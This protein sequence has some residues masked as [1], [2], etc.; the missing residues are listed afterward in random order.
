MINIRKDIRSTI[1]KINDIGKENIVEL[2]TDLNKFMVKTKPNNVSIL[3]RAIPDLDDVFPNMLLVIIVAIVI[4][5][6]GGISLAFMF[7]Y[8]DDLVRNSTHLA[9]ATQWLFLGNVQE[10]KSKLQSKG[11]IIAHLYPLDPVSEAYRIIR[12][13]LLF[14]S[15]E[16]L[17]IK[18][19]SIISNGLG[20]GKTT[21]ACNLAIVMS[22]IGKKVLLID[23]N[24]HKPKLD[25]IFNLK[26][27]TGLG[28]F[29][30][31]Q[32]TIEGIV[33]V[34][35]TPNL[36][37][38]TSGPNPTNPTELISGDKLKKLINMAKQNYDF[39]ILDTAPAG[40]FADA[41][42]IASIVDATIVVVDCKRTPQR[43]LSKIAAKLNE[44][45][46]PKTFFILNR[47]LKQSE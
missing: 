27:S 24:L 37:V 13:S 47:A 16:N 40:L 32:L 28:G 33:N 35:K 4:G 14:Q 44:A 21:T 30:G 3:Q 31:G 6:W 34:I 15:T 2:E 10:M 25:R 12:T 11:N 43:A 7:N 5:L 42:I 19:V 17:P 46:S 1:E 45:R 29:L 38:I 8:L 23:A 20:D 26:N 18:C 36:S 41:A 39:I 9:N 22:Q